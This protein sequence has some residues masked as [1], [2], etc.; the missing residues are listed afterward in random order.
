MT[1]VSA[2]A[3]DDW[4][5]TPEAARAVQKR[6]AASIETED[7][8]GPVRWVAGVDAHYGAGG[9]R[10]WAAVAVL[11]VRDLRVTEEVLI[12]RATP[13]PYVSGL[14]SFREAPAML[15]ALARLSRQPDLLLIDGQGIAHPRRLGLASHV[16]LLADLPAIGVAKTRLVGRFDEPGADRGAW[17]PMIYRGMPVGAALRTRS[18]TR[19]IFVSS[20]HRVALG[21]AIDHVLALSPRYRL[22]E[23][24]RAADRLSRDHPP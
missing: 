23:P 21:T 2:P 24:I 5:A 9:E 18:G 12:D 20:G 22:P 6:L 16:G 17:S 4:P 11:D 7:R 14:L 1:T 10:I 19:P 15:E 13:F 3:S 8:L